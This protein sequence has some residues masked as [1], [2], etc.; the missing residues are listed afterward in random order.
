MNTLYIGVDVSKATLDIQLDGQHQQ[1]QHTQKERLTFIKQ[2]KKLARKQDR[3]IVVV[4]EPS[5]GYEKPLAKDLLD[6]DVPF[7]LAHANNVKA[8]AKSKGYRAKT[9]KI[10][11]NILVE[12]AQAMALSPNQSKIPE[13]RRKI[14]ALIK[15]REQL[16]KER[17]REKLRCDKEMDKEI[18]ASIASHIAWLDKAMSAIDKKLLALRQAPDICDTFQRLTSVPAVGD[19]TALYLIALLPELGHASHQQ[20]A[21]LVGVAPFNHDSGKHRGKRFI[22]GGRKEVRRALYMSAVASLQWNNEMKAF[23]DRLIAKG[24]PAKVALVAII[25]KLLALLNSLMKRNAF[26]E[27][28]VQFATAN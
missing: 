6:N 22:K 15:R 18:Q 23:Y 12:Y 10:D 14:T 28:K 19:I 3:E 9:D 26:W 5:G 21:A 2:L 11:A 1:I 24:K 17:V 4:C 20:I 27:E 25:R 8:F 16:N 7:H 13:N